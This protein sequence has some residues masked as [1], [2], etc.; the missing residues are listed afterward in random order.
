MF[1]LI[2]E[3]KLFFIVLLV[4]VILDLSM[5]LVLPTPYKN[6]YINNYEKVN[7]IGKSW[8]TGSK[9]WGSMTIAYLVAAFGVYY[10]CV[11][12][13]SYLNAILLGIVLYGAYNSVNVAMITN[14]DTKLAAFDTAWGTT[15]ILL[16]TLISLLLGKFLVGNVTNKSI[17]T[18]K[19]LD[20]K[21]SLDSNNSLDIPATALETTTDL[22]SKSDN[23]LGLESNN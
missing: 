21:N 19:S 22:P 20:S 1:N 8:P 6:T 9:L 10:F 18:N 15:L 16:T 12:E 5:K 3:I 17:V 11:K 7:G 4:Y 13:N 2:T 23:E 14:Y